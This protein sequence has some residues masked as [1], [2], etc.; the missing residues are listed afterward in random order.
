MTGVVSKRRVCPH[1]H[2]LP[3]LSDLRAFH[4][5]P[6]LSLSS[7]IRTPDSQPKLKIA[8]SAYGSTNS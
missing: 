6:I 8:A 2:A 3:Q 5:S 7:S 4:S 1:S